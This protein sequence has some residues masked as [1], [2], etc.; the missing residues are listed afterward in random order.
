LAEP[1]RGMVTAGARAD[2]NRVN[3]M[4]SH[5]NVLLKSRDVGIEGFGTVQPIVPWRGLLV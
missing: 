5:E 4:F 3:L 1:D 2:N